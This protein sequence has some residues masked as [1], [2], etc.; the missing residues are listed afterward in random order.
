VL[1]E[2]KSAESARAFMQSP[3]LREVMAKAGVVGPPE[4]ELLE[5]VK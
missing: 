2:W 5:T 3:G 4:I 1:A